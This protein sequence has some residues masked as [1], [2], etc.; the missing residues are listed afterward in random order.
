MPLEETLG[1]FD[2]L[3]QARKVRAVGASNFSGERLAESSKV[4]EREDYEAG[5]APVA[6]EHAFASIPF[7]GL[8][9]GFLTGEYR[10]ASRSGASGSTGSRAVSRTGGHRACS[11]TSCR[12]GRRPGCR[13]P[14]VPAG[15]WD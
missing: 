9:A 7:F 15:A 5:I 8:A 14:G 3:V 1:A 13:R 4:S 2:A 11:P 10:P 12:A 6:A